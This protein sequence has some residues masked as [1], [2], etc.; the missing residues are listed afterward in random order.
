[1]FF[2]EAPPAP[3]LK[4]EQGSHEGNSF[5][6]G[7]YVRASCRVENSRPVSNISWFIDEEPIFQKLGPLE[8]FDYNGDLKTVV[9]NLT[10]KLRYTDNGR[11]LRCVSKHMAQGAQDINQTLFKLNVRCKSV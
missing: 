2:A 8:Y 1:M 11:Y 3:V 7:E 6:E 9:Q 10:H 5:H 4:V